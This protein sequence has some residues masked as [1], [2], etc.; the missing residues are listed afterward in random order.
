M[1][2]H[3]AANG[4]ILFFLW[5]NNIPLYM[6]HIFFMQSSVDVHLGCLHVLII[7]NSATVNTE[8]HV[9]FWIGFLQICAQEWDW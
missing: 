8:V 4:I 9:S 3:V 5:P 1:S 6:Y 2:I 7:V